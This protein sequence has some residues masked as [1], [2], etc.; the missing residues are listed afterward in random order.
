MYVSQKTMKIVVTVITMKIV[1][2]VEILT[3]APKTLIVSH[4]KE[5]LRE[6][7]GLRDRCTAISFLILGDVL[8]KK[9]QEILAN[10]NTEVMHLTVIEVLH[11]LAISVCTDIQI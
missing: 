2:T 10:T 9:G 11:A 3:M 6:M 7:T 4:E 5:M 1:M 8:T